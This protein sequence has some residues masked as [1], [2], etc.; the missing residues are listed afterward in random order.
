MPVRLVMD[1]LVFMSLGMVI[2]KAEDV[3][4][5]ISPTS[6]LPEREDGKPPI[7]KGELAGITFTVI[8]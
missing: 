7:I 4:L 2:V 3:G 1:M 6:S 8:I 5:G